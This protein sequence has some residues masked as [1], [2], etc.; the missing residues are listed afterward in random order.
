[1]NILWLR[2][3]RLTQSSF[4]DAPPSLFLQQLSVHVFLWCCSACSP[5]TA[6]TAAGTGTGTGHPG[7]VAR[8]WH[9]WMGKREEERGREGCMQPRTH[10]NSNL[11]YQKAKW[12]HPVGSGFDLSYCRCFSF[13][14]HASLLPQSLNTLTG[15]FPGSGSG[16]SSHWPETNHNTQGQGVTLIC[17]A[18]VH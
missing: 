5:C 9:I 8:V 4:D 2:E 11:C 15:R 14:P 6:G 12:S 17:T 1:M 16:G 18:V 10:M 13:K 3:C 7:L